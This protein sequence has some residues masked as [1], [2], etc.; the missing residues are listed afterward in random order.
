[1]GEVA[2]WKAA[3]Q[4]AAKQQAK[5]EEVSGIK[6]ISL[7][8][9]CMTIGDDMVPNNTMDVIVLADITE[10]TMYDRPYSPDD[11]APPDCFALGPDPKRLAPHDNVPTP[12]SKACA[13]CPKAEFGTAI[14]GRGPACKTRR[15]L[16]V[17][18]ATDNPEAVG[19]AD[20]ALLKVPPTS[21]VNWSKYVT[22]VAN[23]GVPTWAVATT[24]KA[25]PHPKKQIEVTFAPS[26]QLSDAMMATVY[27]RLEE[28]ASAANKPFTYDQD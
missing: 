21:V 28:A 11:N 1:M 5:Q 18:P 17:M 16:I 2:N 10:R 13:K 9:G 26:K 20:L 15:R 6:Y 4:E 3:L 23:K 25:G 24:V 14:Q 22:K 7:A 19:E 12:I 27:E 8:G